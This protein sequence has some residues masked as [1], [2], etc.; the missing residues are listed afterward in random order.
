MCAWCTLYTTKK[1]RVV[2]RGHELTVRNI[3]K[4]F[5]GYFPT[6]IECAALARASY[7]ESLQDAVAEIDSS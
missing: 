7:I 6:P 3:Y 1:W 2:E 5:I 4:H